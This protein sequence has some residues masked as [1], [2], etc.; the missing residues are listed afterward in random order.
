[1]ER[2]R[3][4]Y[5]KLDLEERQILVRKHLEIGPLAQLSDFLCCDR[6][7]VMKEVEKINLPTLILCGEDDQLTPVKYSQFLQSRIKVSR[8]EVLPHAGHMVMMESPQAFN[9]KIRAFI[10]D[11]L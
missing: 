9:E 11:N 3:E 10:I 2:L 4:H 7:D 6:F 1:M 5:S 8:L